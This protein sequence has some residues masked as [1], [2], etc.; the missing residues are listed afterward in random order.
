MTPRFAIGTQYVT[1]HKHPR[2]CTVV[3]ILTTYNSKGECV[4][5][6]YVATHEFIGQTVTEYD[7]TDTTIA[8]GLAALAA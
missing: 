4:R 6:R 1:R 5:I 3:D 8:M 7:V 2:H